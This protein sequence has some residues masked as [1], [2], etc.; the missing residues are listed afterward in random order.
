MNAPI[1]TLLVLFVTIFT[2]SALA[3]APASAKRRSVT[4]G[5]W[6]PGSPFG[7]KLGATNRLEGTIGRRVKIVNWYQDWGSQD[8]EHFKYNVTKAVRGVVRSGRRPMLTWEPYPL[9]NGAPWNDYSNDAIASGRYDGLI[10]NWAA[11]V[12]RLRTPVYVRFAHEF[13]GTWYP[14]GGPV[15]DNSPQSYKRMWTRVVD[16]ARSAGATNIRWVWSPLAEDV[17]NE[18]VNRFENYYPGPGYVDVLALDGYNWGGGTPQFGGWR[19]FREIFKKAYKR[20]RRLGPQPIWIAEVGSASDGGNKARWV[21]NMFRTA[22]KWKRLK[23]IV[24]YD[25]DKERDWSTASAASAFR[26]PRR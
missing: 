6:T 18:G 20:I 25:Q 19:T 11:G 5:A 21:R 2:V 24:W 8:R 23:A 9:A 1:R 17:P 16:V 22:R 14:W 12:A 3:P 4:F 15:N 7:G 13:N 10:R 26:S